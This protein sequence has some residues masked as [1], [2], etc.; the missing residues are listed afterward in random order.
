MDRDT[1]DVGLAGVAVLC[2]SERLCECVTIL[3]QLHS[4]LSPLFLW[5]A[6]LNLAFEDCDELLL[7]R[8]RKVSARHTA[9]LLFGLL[10]RCFQSS[11]LGRYRE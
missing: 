2:E 10:E 7:L 5:L 8:Q 4:F 1:A 3:S 6:L 11:S 9:R